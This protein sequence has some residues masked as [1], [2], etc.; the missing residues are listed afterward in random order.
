MVPPL[1]FR[2]T[3]FALTVL[4]L[5]SYSGVDLNNNGV[6]DIWEHKYKA[7]SL[8]ADAASKAADQDGDGQ[9]N[10]A[11]SEAGTDP[12]DRS[13]VHRVGTIQRTNNDV[14]I[15][16][17]AQK[18]KVYQIYNSDTLLSDSWEMLGEPIIATE[19]E[20]STLI[21]NQDDDTM[22]YRIEVSDIDSDDDG[23]PDWDENQLEG[24]DAGNDDSFSSGNANNDLS[25][26]NA[27]MHSLNA[28]EITITASTPEAFEKEATAAVFTITRTG[29][30]TYPATLFLN[31]SGA[32][33]TPKSSATAT[34][35][36]L[37][38]A[39]GLAIA[40]SISIPAGASSVELHC[41]PILDAL[42]EVPEAL[43]CQL[44]DSAQAATVHICDATN[45]QA[46]N[47]LYVAQLSPETGAVSSGSG[48]ATILLK[49]DNTFGEV[50]MTFYGLSSDQTA[51]HIHIKN[52]ITG[53]PVRSVPRGQ[54]DGLIWDILAAQFIPT[55]QGM[56]DALQQGRI[57]INVHST[58]YPSGEIRGDFSPET[59][60]V[61]IDAPPAPPEMVAL[62]GDALDRDIARFLTQG[63]FG[64]TPELMAELRSLVESAPHHGD[65]ISAFGAWIDSQLAMDSPDLELIIYAADAHERFLRSIEGSPDYREDYGPGRNN[66]L[67]CW[68]LLARHSEDQLRQRAAF[69]LSEIFVTSDNDAI[70][71]QRHYGQA[72][73]HDMLK[74]GVTGSY[75]DLLEG[76]ATHPIMGQYL[77]HLQNSKAI[78]DSG[79]NVIVSPDENFAR[80]IMQLFSIGLVQ[81]HADG[82]LKIDLQGLPIPTYAQDDISELS[83]VFTGWSFSKENS[84][85]YTDNVSTNT[86]CSLSNGSRYYQA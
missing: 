78:Y 15:D 30:A 56:L 79:G 18:G 22:F 19:Q 31:F 61:A 51:A 29:D 26:A 11:E 71:Y 48:L 76:V 64:P 4:I 85:D 54:I 57:Y 60:S 65:R 83:R 13:S 72:N 42:M 47:R 46:N 84:P 41:H 12:W 33:E 45:I 2:I 68:W 69:A 23:I 38:N 80:E 55:D 34:D 59:G 53:P 37:K 27:M 36:A 1:I 7:S 9:S 77:S 70:V 43:T 82:S 28:G 75:R 63:T 3:A 35:Y 81:L 66:R 44:G 50:N 40:G 86:R 73:Y 5:P 16:L 58:N 74:A 67:S 52:P 62:T 17:P 25:A 10:F 8:V 32:T 24:F 21:A 49:G 39:G 6:S 14:A 20:I